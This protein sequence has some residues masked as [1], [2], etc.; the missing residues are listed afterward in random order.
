MEKAGKPP[1]PF[2]ANPAKVLVSTLKGKTSQ[3]FYH[4]NTMVGIRDLELP[5]MPYSPD[6]NWTHFAHP[7]RICATPLYLASTQLQSP[8]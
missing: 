2:Y 6:D 8:S 1:R 5:K 4:L 7:F 3:K